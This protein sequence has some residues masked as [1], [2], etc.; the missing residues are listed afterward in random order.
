MIA[1][2]MPMALALGEGGS[3]PRPSAR[4]VIGGL[5]ASTS[6]C[7]SFC[8]WSLAPLNGRRAETLARST[9]TMRRRRHERELMNL[10]RSVLPMRT[11]NAVSLGVVMSAVVAIGVPLSPTL[12]A[13]GGSGSPAVTGGKAIASDLSSYVTGATLDVNGGMLIH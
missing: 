1:G 10:E 8:R 9:L 5:V 12:R 6:P 13:Q 2:M 3:R 4:A 11:M 7:S